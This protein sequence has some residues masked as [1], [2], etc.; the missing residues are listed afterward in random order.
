MKSYILWIS[1][2]LSDTRTIYHSRIDSLLLPEKL[3]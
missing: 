2:V 3:P 1:L